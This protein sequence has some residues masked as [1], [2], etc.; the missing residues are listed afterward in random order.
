VNEEAA[1]RASRRP[2]EQGGGG[3]GEDVASAAE[4]TRRRQRQCVH[5]RLGGERKW[6]RRE[7]K[8]KEGIA[9]LPKAAYICHLTDKYRWVVYLSA[10][11]PLYSLIWPCNRRI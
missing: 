8:T 6:G 11:C 2:G 1:G 5:K 9:P 3:S 10:L 4:T 7:R